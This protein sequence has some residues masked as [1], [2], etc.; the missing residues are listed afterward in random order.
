MT[1]D[2]QLGEMAQHSSWKDGWLCLSYDEEMSREVVADNDG[3]CPHCKKEVR[4]DV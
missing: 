4:A 2:A 1:S 3:Y